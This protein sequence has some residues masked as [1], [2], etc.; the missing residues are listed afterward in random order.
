MAGALLLFLP[1]CA[2]AISGGSSVSPARAADELLAADRAF[3]SGA[4]DLAA[5]LGAMFA[6][7]V[8]VP[9]PDGTFARGR[10]AALDIVRADPDNSGRQATWAPVRAGVSADG[11]HGFTFGYMTLRNADGR[12]S[13][14]K[15]LS[16]W[17]KS[18]DS[19]KVAAH[20]RRPA[21]DSVVTTALLPP[22]V[23]AAY[24]V[25][26][27]NPENRA[28]YERSLTAAEQ[29]FS[30]AAQR[31]GLTRAF[32]EFGRADAVNMGDPDSGFIHGNDAIGSAV[33]AG[34]PADASPVYWRADEVR[35][36]P[37]GD[38]GITFGFVRLHEPTDA[39]R[40]GF[41]FFTIWKRDSAA[42]TWRYIAE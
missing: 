33:G 31:I 36:A 27:D 39:T 41:P 25:P 42:A 37:S 5:A 19:W 2:P 26:N 10:A 17:I 8:I 21:R 16:Y 3:G 6:E 1:G 35:V 22:S 18:G 9:A 4:A 12:V 34:T 14:A 13:H 11:L 40:G 23:P 15:Y 38:L 29:A 32:Q 30:D 7:D 20:R 24:V 28:A